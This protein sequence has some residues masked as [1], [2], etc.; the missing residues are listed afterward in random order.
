MTTPNGEY[1]R[2]KLPKFSD[3]PAQRHTSPHNS[4]PTRTATS[5]CFTPRRSH[6]S[7]SGAGL[8]LVDVRLPNPLTAGNM[9]LEPLLKRCPRGLCCG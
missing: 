6:H 1:V 8:R 5:S 4:S 7:P 3:C 9:K 2:N